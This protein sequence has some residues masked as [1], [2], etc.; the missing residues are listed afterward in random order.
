MN[1]W[2]HC[3][4]EVLQTVLG[5]PSSLLE[6]RV[7]LVLSFLMMWLMVSRAGSL[8][9]IRN[10]RFVQTLI[11]TFVGG[12]LS[13]AALAAVWMYLPSWNHS[14]YRLWMDI[15]VLSAVTLFLIAPFMKLFQK[16][17]YMTAVMT[18]ILAVAGAAV[19]ILLGSALF[20]SFAFG[21]QDAEKG[22]VHKEEIEQ[23]QQ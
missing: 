16:A 4:Q 18:W 7:L 6:K 1:E 23:I 20:E 22:R 13:L 21:S 8:L 9:G 2:G 11:I 15:G 5:D 10:S 19:V 3:F 12:V 14:E 17:S